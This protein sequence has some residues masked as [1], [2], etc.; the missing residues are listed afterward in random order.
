MFSYALH[1]FPPPRQAIAH[2]LAFASQGIVFLCLFDSIRE[3]LPAT[4]VVGTFAAIGLALGFL[5]QRW[6]TMPHKIEMIIGML[7]FGNLGML[8]GWLA[9]NGFS[10]LYDGS[11]SHC[12]ESMRQGILQPWMWLGM[13][14][15][16][17]A[18][19]MWFMRCVLVPSPTH[20]L[21]M[22]TGGNVGMFIGMLAGGWCVDQIPSD[23]VPFAACVSFVGMS[24]GMIA[25]MLFGTWL[26]EKAIAAVRAITKQQN[27]WARIRDTAG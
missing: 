4:V 10:P 5:W 17:N 15:G 19:M 11:C 12:I 18:A 6:T 3:L 16:A 20:S 8:F 23:S 1:L 7:T 24:L 21:A 22:Y 27:F 14:V 9:D 25:G 2:G 26:V 13:F